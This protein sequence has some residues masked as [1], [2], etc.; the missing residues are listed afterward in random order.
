MTTT[1]SLINC[2][3]V[4][5]RAGKQILMRDIT[6]KLVPRTILHVQGPNGCGKSTLLKTLAGQLKAAHGQIDYHVK[7]DCIFYLPQLHTP[8]LHCPISLREISLL[9]TSTLSAN[10]VEQFEWF[11]DAVAAKSWNNA[12]GGERMRALLARALSSRRQILLL[13]EPFN[14][15]DRQAHPKIIES[16]KNYVQQ[17]NRAIIIV[18]H[19]SLQHNQ[20]DSDNV[21]SW[22]LTNHWQASQC[23]I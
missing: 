23:S 10:L 21:I 19:E 3:N 12:S 14:H 2:Q 8:D 13:D 15:L 4:S 17:D 20:N 6:L 22:N 7:K 11:P 16:L 18:S 9:D 1:S 5:L